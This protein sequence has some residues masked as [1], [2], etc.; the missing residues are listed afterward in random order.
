MHLSETTKGRDRGPCA[1]GFS[2]RMVD[3][4]GKSFIAILFTDNLKVAGYTAEI[5]PHARLGEISLSRRATKASSSSR[6]AISNAG[7]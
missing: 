3:S 6:R 4:L 5:F 2:H 1:L 7:R